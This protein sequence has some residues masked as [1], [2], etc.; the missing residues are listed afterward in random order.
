MVALVTQPDN[1]STRHRDAMTGDGWQTDI[2]PSDSSPFVVFVA[3]APPDRRLTA[4]VPDR[5][6]SPLFNRVL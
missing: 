1:V 6:F 2:S 5:S 3:V 4:P